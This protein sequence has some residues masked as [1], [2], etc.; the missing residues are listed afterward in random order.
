MENVKVGFA[1][2]G[3]FCTLKKSIEALKVLKEQKADIF[4]V[5][6]TSAFCRMCVPHRDSNCEI[7]FEKR[8]SFWRRKM[9]A[10]NV[11]VTLSA[12][13][14]ALPDPTRSRCRRRCSLPMLQRFPTGTCCPAGTAATVP[15]LL[16]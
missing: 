5:G 13:A 15:R 12:F 8:V 7:H 11:M 14:A 4:P 10:E 6:R 16:R 3:S 9:H 2:C 1:F